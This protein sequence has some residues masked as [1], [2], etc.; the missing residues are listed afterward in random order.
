MKIKHA[1]PQEMEKDRRYMDVVSLSTKDAVK[2]DAFTRISYSL[3]DV[4]L[5]DGDK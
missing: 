5:K 4:I 3:L 2:T 1:L